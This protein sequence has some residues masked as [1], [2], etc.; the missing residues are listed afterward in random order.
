M[1]ETIKEYIIKFELNILQD[2]LSR[3]KEINAPNIVI[4]TLQEEINR[5]KEGILKLTNG[6]KL[7]EQYEV[8]DPKIVKTGDGGYCL[9]QFG[10]KIEYCR[11]NRNRYVRK[12]Y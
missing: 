6:K 3:L 12:C 1:K 9:I 2:R 5:L 7:S 11:N 4:N 8:V 10:N